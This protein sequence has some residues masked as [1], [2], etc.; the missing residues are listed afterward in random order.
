M[1]RPS[2]PI[3]SGHGKVYIPQ[4][5]VEQMN[6]S[7][8]SAQSMGRI[9]DEPPKRAVV[10]YDESRHA[11][12]EKEKER[13]K[14]KEK[15]KEKAALA[16]V[17][18][19]EIA[20]QTDIDEQLRILEECKKAKQREDNTSADRGVLTGGPSA[21]RQYP[22]AQQN[23]PQSSS[24]LG[25]QS[26]STQDPYQFSHSQPSSV[27]LQGDWSSPLVVG[28]AV[29][30]PKSNPPIYG[31]IRWIGTIPQVQG[32]VAGVELVSNIHVY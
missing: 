28:S 3:S 31:T 20:G 23:Y 17:L 4:S 27:P 25:R 15:E 10:K 11:A 12:V 2:I 9:K 24:H 22:A 7:V 5:M 6:D 18:G 14:E 13:E 26:N 1:N 16:K 19:P 30:L 8:I 29:I 32:F 21:D